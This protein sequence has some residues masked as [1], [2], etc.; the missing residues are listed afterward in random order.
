MNRVELMKLESQNVSVNFKTFMNIIKSNQLPVCFEGKDIQYYRN[1]IEQYLTENFGY[2]DCNGKSKVLSLRE[3]IQKNSQYKD[4]LCLYFVDCDFDDNANI[5]NQDNVYI[6][7]CYSIENLYTSD[8][9]FE[10]IISDEFS[11]NPNNND[12]LE[13]FNKILSEY[14][15]RKQEFFQCIEEFNLYVYSIKEMQINIPY[16]DIKISKFIDI[17]LNLV[18]KKY[19]N[20]SEVLVNIDSYSLDLQNARNYFLG[21]EPEKFFRG[22]NNFQFLE[23]F[24]NKLRDDSTQKNITRKFFS[25]KTNIDFSINNLLSSISKYAETPE[26]LIEFLSKHKSSISN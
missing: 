5:C 13:L 16:N 8:K 3:E 9:V 4:K 19:N 12:Q 14:K 10:K 2:I 17:E 23:I 22:K 15:V 7:P 1:R 20:I 6:T 25:K 18:N 26:C 24:L 11:I 21:K